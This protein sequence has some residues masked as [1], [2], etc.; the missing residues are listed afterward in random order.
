MRLGR[1]MWLDARSLA[2][3]VENDVEEM[4]QS[5]AILPR[6][7]VLTVLDQGRSAPA[8]ATP[9][10]APR[11]PA[12]LRRGRQ[13]RPARPMT[14]RART[15]AV[16]LYAD[17]TVVDGY[18]GTY[19]PDDT[20]SSGLAIC[21]VLNSRGTI[22]GYRFAR[23]AYGFLRL[24][25]TVRCCRACPG[26]RRSSRPTRTASSTPA[27]TG[28]PAGSRRPRNRGGRRRTRHHRCVQQ[29]DHLRQQLG[30]RLGRLGPVPDAAANLRAA[31]RGRPEAVPHVTPTL[32]RESLAWSPSP[33]PPR[34][35]LPPKGKES[36]HRPCASFGMSL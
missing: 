6:E 3:M 28:R 20:G 16:Q 32:T 4:G 1:N 29:R 5:L 27:R 14:K 26:T 24:L 7:R 25:R 19:P 33:S 21:K 34:W 15:F 9:A 2:H 17:A 18:P 12:V 11:H 31:H 22:K 8:P 10:P 13:L 23:T 30:Q 36:H 35:A